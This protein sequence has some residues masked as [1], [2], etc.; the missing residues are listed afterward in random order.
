MASVKGSCEFFR[1]VAGSSDQQELGTLHYSIYES[2]QDRE[3]IWKSHDETL[4]RKQMAMWLP[5]GVT[6]EDFLKT[7]QNLNYGAPNNGLPEKLD[8]QPF[9]ESVI[10]AA[11]RKFLPAHSAIQRLRKLAQKGRIASQLEEGLP[12]VVWGQSIEDSFE[13]ADGFG[14]IIFQDAVTEEKGGTDT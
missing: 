12:K 4:E 11:S 5:N 2:H 10:S 6:V 13:T 1:S 9:D 14:R 3:A 7:W 8:E